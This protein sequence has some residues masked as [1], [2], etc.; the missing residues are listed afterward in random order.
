MRNEEDKQI[1]EL[2]S[3]LSGHHPYV[4]PD[5]KHDPGWDYTEYVLIT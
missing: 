5:A 1:C 3:I 4:Y 2:I